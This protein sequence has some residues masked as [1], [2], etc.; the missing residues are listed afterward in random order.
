MHR[1]PAER[2]RRSRVDRH[3]RPPYSRK[4]AQRI[5][6]GLLKGG[7]AVDGADAEEK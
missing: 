4:D 3:I 2:L 6:G 7:I 1:I 5:I